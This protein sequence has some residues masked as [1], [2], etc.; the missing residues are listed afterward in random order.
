MART[1]AMIIASASTQAKIGRSMKNLDNTAAL[2]SRHRAWPDF[3]AWPQV[4]Q[5][6]DDQLVSWLEAAL[7]QPFVAD[8]LTCLDDA[9]SHDVAG[10]ENHGHRLTPLV[11]GDASL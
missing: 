8:R 11:V 7:D 2:A 4:Q 1:P 10:S 3:G 9:L 5:A 6:V